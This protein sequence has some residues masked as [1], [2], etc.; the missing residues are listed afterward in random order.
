MKARCKRGFSLV[1]MIT[2]MAIVGF[3]SIGLYQF[4]ANTSMALFKNT[5]K[6]KINK[7]V[8]W[9]TSELASVAR[10]ANA[11]YIYRSF[12]GTDRDSS[13]DRQRDGATGDM[14]VLIFQS[15]FPT[16]DDP[17]YVTRLVC[18]YREPDPEDPDGRGPVFEVDLAYTPGTV[19]ASA[20]PPETLIENA[21]NNTAK[22]KKREVLQLSR[23]LADGKL[24]YNFRDRAVV[25]K[26]EI[27]HGN[28][29]KR[30]TDTYNFTI[31]PRG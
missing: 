12:K 16:V 11:F 13:E 6:L 5:E 18:F 17:D 22:W 15:P 1:E 24:F 19:L 14:M 21:S 31:S 3:L 20:N 26:G 8:R 25:V 29:A 4:T 2:V 27:I 28:D 23:G 30:V 9:F 7:D 10:A